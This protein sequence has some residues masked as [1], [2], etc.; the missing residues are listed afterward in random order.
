MDC[1]FFFNSRRYS[2]DRKVL[3]TKI[4]RISYMFNL[5]IKIKQPIQLISQYNRKFEFIIMPLFGK[6]SCF[7]DGRS[8]QNTFSCFAPM[9]RDILIRLVY[10]IL[11][12]LWSYISQGR[13]DLQGH[14]IT[15]MDLRT[16]DI[17]FITFD[18][19][20]YSLF[21]SWWQERSQFRTDSELVR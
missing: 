3:K 11:L 4:W 19:D 6:L 8:M 15:S 10:L 1:V 18:N 20:N 5:P 2:N 9:F 7:A 13:C 21:T 12:A 17:L 16:C 14:K